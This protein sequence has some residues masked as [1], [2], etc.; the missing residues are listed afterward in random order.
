MYISSRKCVATVTDC[1]EFI[2]P[3][4]N[5]VSIVAAFHLKY[6]F[7]NCCDVF[8]NCYINYRL[9]CGIDNSY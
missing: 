3:T 1:C 7:F 5:Q 4:Y 2:L 6:L 9:I 8:I